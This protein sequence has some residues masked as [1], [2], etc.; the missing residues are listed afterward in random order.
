MLAASLSPPPPQQVPSTVTIV[1]G[2]VG[3]W[4]VK[5]CWQICLVENELLRSLWC[6]EVPELFMV[7]SRDGKVMLWCRARSDHIVDSWYQW[8]SHY[9]AGNSILAARH[10]PPPRAQRTQFITIKP[11]FAIFGQSI[12]F[13]L[14]QL[15][16]MVNTAWCHPCKKQLILLDLRKLSSLVILVCH[17]CLHHKYQSIHA[18]TEHV[19]TWKARDIKTK[20][21][22]PRE[23]L[24]IFASLKCQKILNF[25][26]YAKLARATG[27]VMGFPFARNSL[28]LI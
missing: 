24:G 28:L 4:I 6:H 18:A 19:Y 9:R 25:P 27:K 15:N 8:Q 26:S 7:K 14:K 10:A 20:K 3:H 11:D 17:F 16:P 2:A 23:K 5:E 1:L 13:Y 21:A 22:L 12:F